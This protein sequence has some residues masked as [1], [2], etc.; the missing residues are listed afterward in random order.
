MARVVDIDLLGQRVIY[1]QAELN[2]K[3]IIPYDHLVIAL[4]SVTRMPAIRG[5]REHGF[6]MKDLGDA[7]ALRDRA[8]EMLELADSSDESI[9]RRLLHFVVVGGSFTGVEVAG[10]FEFFKSVCP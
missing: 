7:I 5:L 10:E 2:K 9:R 1:Q 6:T 8:I 3:K 4:G